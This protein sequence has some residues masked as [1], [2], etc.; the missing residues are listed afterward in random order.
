MSAA[1]QIL[2]QA[3]NKRE[4]RKYQFKI[5]DTPDYRLDKDVTTISASDLSNF[6]A[7]SAK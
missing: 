7:I 6:K 4:D 2:N 1:Q 3:S 5:E